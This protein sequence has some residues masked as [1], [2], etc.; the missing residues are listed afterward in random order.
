[1][2]VVNP[3]PLNPPKLTSKIVLSEKQDTLSMETFKFVPAF[4]GLHKDL[5]LGEKIM[6]VAVIFSFS[7]RGY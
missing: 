5:L 6:T 7:R 3:P 4:N 2:G 1:M